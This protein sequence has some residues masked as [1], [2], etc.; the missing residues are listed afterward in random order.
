M[1]V[2]ICPIC[3]EE[4][5]LVNQ[6]CNHSFCG[7]CITQMIML[8]AEQRALPCPLCRNTMVSTERRFILVDD[9]RLDRLASLIVFWILSLGFLI[10]TVLYEVYKKR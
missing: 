4:K 6:D 9:D 7:D 8:N 2:D 1:P 10:I 3:L 5:I